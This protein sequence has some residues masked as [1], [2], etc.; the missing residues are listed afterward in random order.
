MYERGNTIRLESGQIVALWEN[1]APANA[2][3]V[4]VLW[5]DGGDSMGTSTWMSET[6]LDKGEIVNFD[7][8]DEA[9]AALHEAW[10]GSGSLSDSLA[11]RGEGRTN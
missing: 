2:W 11:A 6:L 9:L 4:L 10:A 5:D 3:H 8:V 1:P 7:E